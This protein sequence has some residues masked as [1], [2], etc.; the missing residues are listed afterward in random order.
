MAPQPRV[1]RSAGVAAVARKA[2]PWD[3][4]PPDF[5]AGLE[6]ARELVARLVGGDA[7]GVFVAPSVSY[8][9]TTAAAVLPLDR[10]QRVL[11]LDDQF[12]SNV[13]PWRAAAARH[14]AE[15]VTVPRPPDDDWTAA[16]L[17]CIDPLTGVVAVPQCHWMDGSRVDLQALRAATRAVGATVAV[18]ATQSLGA[19][20]FDVA[21]LQPDMVVAA[22]YK[23]LLGPTS[24]AFC[25]VAPEWRDGGPIDG[26]WL[27]RKG[28]EDFARLSEYPEAF[29][30][31]ARRYDMGGSYNFVLLPM[32]NAAMELVLGWG[33][34]RIHATI[35]GH[36]DYLAAALCDLG[37]TAVRRPQRFGHL[38]GVRLPPGTAR[39]VAERLAVA[40]VYA[41]V[42]G[43]TLRLSPHVY[44][45]AEDLARFLDALSEALHRS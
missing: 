35:T 24:L 7:D 8:A 20:P 31:G 42:R 22:A 41:S 45:D 37:V 27:S 44:N 30:P 3:I 13:Y 40:G 32:A 11:V 5:L 1:V 25:W 19:V 26:Y 6:T 34:E 17:E 39:A 38:M 14:G 10:G 18:D 36:T 33:V 28:S 43:T 15:V 9:M 12:P 23:W 29:Q 4:T 16:L 21:T 2:A